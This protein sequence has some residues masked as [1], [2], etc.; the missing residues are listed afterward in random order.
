MD[1][2]DDL[3]VVARRLVQIE[4]EMLKL[5]TEKD[6]LIAANIDLWTELNKVEV[7]PAQGGPRA[8]YERN[9]SLISRMMEDYEDDVFEK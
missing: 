6:A 2:R 3:K 9:S 7:L 8:P 4:L 5:K 1:L